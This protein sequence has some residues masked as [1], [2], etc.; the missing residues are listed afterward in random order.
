[1]WVRVEAKA[2]GVLLSVE[3]A[4]PG[5]PEDLRTGVFEPFRQ[6]PSKDE[7]S[8]GVGIGLSLVARFAKLHG[9]TAWLEDRPGGGAAF[10]VSLP[11]PVTRPDSEGLRA[12]HRVG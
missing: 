1:M 12:E 10:R 9:G 7:H 8:P 11:A 6:G 2:D 3:D 5:V 4:G